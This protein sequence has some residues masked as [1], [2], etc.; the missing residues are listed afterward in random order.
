MSLGK[1]DRPNITNGLAEWSDCMEPAAGIASAMV[2]PTPSAL[3]GI[4]VQSDDITW[5]SAAGLLRT[6][7]TRAPG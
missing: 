5:A 4:P 2:R 3:A 1:H 6:H 7:L